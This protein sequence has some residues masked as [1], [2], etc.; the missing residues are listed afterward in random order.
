MLIRWLQTL[1]LGARDLEK[2]QRDFVP[3]SLRDV[4]QGKRAEVRWSDIGGKW[5]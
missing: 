5:S 4:Q 3:L 1:T 2:A